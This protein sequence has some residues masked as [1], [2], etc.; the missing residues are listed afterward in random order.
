MDRLAKGGAVIRMESVQADERG[1]CD[2]C[3]KAKQTRATYPRSDSRAGKVLELSH[4]D[5]MGP[6]L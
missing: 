1:S 3:L 4:T 6:F 2:V 5:V